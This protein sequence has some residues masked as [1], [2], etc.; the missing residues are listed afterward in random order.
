MAIS[1]HHNPTTTH[2]LTTRH[3]DASPKSKFLDVPARRAGTRE[4]HGAIFSSESS[5]I[6]ASP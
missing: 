4:D 5:V 1:E 2:L 3:D 6:D